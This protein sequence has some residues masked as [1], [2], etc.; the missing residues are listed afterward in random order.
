MAKIKT[1][2]LVDNMAESSD[3][4]IDEDLAFNSDNER[5]YGEMF[6]PKMSA[7]RKQGQQP[8]QKKRS[9]LGADFESEESSIDDEESDNENNESDK[10]DDDGI[11][12]DD[13]GDGGQFMLDIL[14]NL[15]KK[16]MDN[17]K[18]VEDLR[19][20]MAHSTKEVPESEFAAVSNS[21]NQHTN[22]LTLDQLMN[23]ITNTKGFKSVKNVMKDMTSSDIYDNDAFQTNALSTT[24]TPMAKIISKRAEQK[25]HYIEQSKNVSGW[26]EVVKQNR[27]AETLDFRPKDRIRM[28][29]AE[30]VH[31]FEPT[32]DFEKEMT[33]FLIHYRQQLL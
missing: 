21:N 32:T 28:N 15:D 3:E 1:L 33:E 12:S 16:E 10:S 24:K 13:D 31:K 25:V 4:E 5:M 30:L 14:N 22:R 18:E 2:Q 17:Q 27:E 23:G 8:K 20:L 9:K 6:Q 29:K 19:A 26:T 7:K 11:A